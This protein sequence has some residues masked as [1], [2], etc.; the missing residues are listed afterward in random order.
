MWRVRKP[1]QL[2]VEVYKTCIGAVNDEDLKRRLEQ[3]EV[4]I[5]QEAQLYDV[6]AAQGKLHTLVRTR[7]IDGLVTVEEMS[8][9]YSLRFAKQGSPGRGVYDELMSATRNGR[10]P[11]CGHGAVS[12]LDHF[13][14]KSQYPCLSVLPS[15]LVPA[16][17]DCNKNKSRRFPR[18]PDE[19]TL[20]PY[21]DDIE[22]DP[23]LGA[24]VLEG[25]PAAV[26]FFVEAVGCWDQVKQA[27]VERHFKLLKLAK[28]YTANA[29]DE[30][31]SIREN[32]R[33]IIRAGATGA[34][35]EYLR[36]EAQ[37]RS[38]ARLNS[39]QTAMYTALAESAW[40]CGGGFE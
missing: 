2:A 34:V 10:C 15:N 6:A 32:L 30:L 19:A 1:S 22:E 9:L 11:L 27:R 13:L 4:T 25:K 31:V 37:S 7:L 23:W 39:W 20:H 5:V 26:R 28:L 8:D 29:A 24:Q 21:F 38:V 36:E 33:R 17:M 35:K 14:P 40:Y 18:S 16:C 3:V 12:T